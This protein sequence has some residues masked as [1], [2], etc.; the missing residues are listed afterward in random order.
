MPGRSWRA[1]KAIVAMESPKALMRPLEKG[2]R[3]ID[4]GHQMPG[5]STAKRWPCALVR[6]CPAR[7][8]EPYYCKKL[9]QNAQFVRKQVGFHG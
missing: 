9:T 4:I 6:G 8:H 1:G 3:G 5:R 7:H 2:V